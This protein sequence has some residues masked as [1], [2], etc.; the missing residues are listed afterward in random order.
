M[1]YKHYAKFRVVTPSCRG[2]R[3]RELAERKRLVWEAQVTRH[4]VAA[5]LPVR[6]QRQRL[7]AAHVLS[8]PDA[9]AIV[10]HLAELLKQP[11]NLRRRRVMLPDRLEDRIHSA[12]GYL[13]PYEYLLKVTKND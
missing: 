1:S 2:G 9:D 8:E 5:E 12:L 13:T 3:L 10:Q 6:L 4:I 11:S 7:Q